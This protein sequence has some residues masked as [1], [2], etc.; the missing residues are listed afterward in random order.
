MQVFDWVVIAIAAL[1]AYRGWRRGLVREFVELAVL[2]AGT[3]IVFRMAPAVGAVLSGMANIPPEG[4][5]VVGG[6]VILIVLIVGS[7]F[8]SRIIA[9]ALKVVPGATTLNR[10]GGALVGIGYTFLFVVVATTLV[11]AAPLPTGVRDSFDSSVENSIVGAQ[12][13]APEGIVQRSFSSVSGEEV[14]GAVIAVRDA[15]GDRLMAGTLPIPLPVIGNAALVPSQSA[16]QAVFDDL[17][18]ERISAGVDPVAWS[19]DLAI[20]AV[21]RSNEVYRSGF[22]RLDDNLDAALEAEGIP[23]TITSEMLVIAAT[24]D[25]ISE[26]FTS[27]APYRATIVDPAFRKAGVGVVDGPYGLI[28]VAV[29]SG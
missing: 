4:A 16:A 15:V 29:F 17:N 22:L 28:S 5:R 14:F 8:A 13:V 6:L 21:A 1:F 12:I 18:A 2:F 23:G 9:A 24:P 3:V 19:P 26:A 7:F 25:G 20:V 10:L 11:S 27:V